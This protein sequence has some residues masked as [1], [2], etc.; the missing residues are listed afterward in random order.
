MTNRSR[1]APG[2]FGFEGNE[3]RRGCSDTFDEVLARRLHRRSVLK[4]GVLAP[5][6]SMGTI[7]N[8]KG[9]QDGSG[10]Q[11]APIHKAAPQT[12]SA[13]RRVTSGRRWQLGGSR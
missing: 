12:R 2:D 3:P 13:C 4:G 6:F 7:A 8:L 11:F 1:I 5:L 10:L 9:Q